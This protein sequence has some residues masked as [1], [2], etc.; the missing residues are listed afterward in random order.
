M[1][2]T[3]NGLRGKSGRGA[4]ATQVATQ[5]DPG[6]PPMKRAAIDSSTTITTSATSTTRA[7]EVRADT[8]V[9]RPVAAPAGRT[10]LTR[11]AAASNSSSLLPSVNR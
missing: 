6:Q 8:R 7:T 9:K 4:T 11:A 3:L 5:I 2:A 10:A 1:Q